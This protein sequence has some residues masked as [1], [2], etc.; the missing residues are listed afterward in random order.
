MGWER[1]SYFKSMAANLKVLTEPTS[2]TA[3]ATCT[4]KGNVEHPSRELLNVFSSPPNVTEDGKIPTAGLR[5]R[6][7]ISLV[8][9]IS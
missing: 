3:L 6:G 7:M 1:I 9:Q 8:S 5:K 2:G 4:C